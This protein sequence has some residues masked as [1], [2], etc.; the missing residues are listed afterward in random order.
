M[1]FPYSFP[2]DFDIVLTSSEAGTSAEGSPSLI[3]GAMDVGLGLEAVWNRAAV[4]SDVGGGL[5][6]LKALWG[7]EG[8]VTDMQLSGEQ[9]R[10]NITSRQVSKPFKGVNL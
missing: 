4:L 7:M 2:F 3:I 5:D 10:L 1:P 8:P 6:A 9:G